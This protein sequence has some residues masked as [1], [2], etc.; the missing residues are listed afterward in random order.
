MNATQPCDPG[1]EVGPIPREALN[2]LIRRQVIRSLGSPGDLLKVQVRPVGGDRY[3]VNVLVGKDAT[4]A[5]IADSFFLTADDE[6]TIVTS[7]PAIAR[8][9]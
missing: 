6:G 3:R 5:R 9:Y 1:K 7:T 8:R 4:S 2:A